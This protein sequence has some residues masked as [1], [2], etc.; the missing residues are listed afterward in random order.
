M[1]G[2]PL[3]HVV[4]DFD[5]T[6]G[7]AHMDLTQVLA[8]GGGEVAG[9]LSLR[10]TMTTSFMGGPYSPFDYNGELV[11]I[12]SRLEAITRDLLF[13]FN[14][15]Y[16]GADED[17]TPAPPIG[18][19]D[20]SSVDLNGNTAPSD[21][22]PNSPFQLFNAT[23]VQDSF[24]NNI[25]DQFDGVNDPT[26]FARTITFNITDPN[27]IQASADLDPTNAGSIV[28]A[29][30]DAT[31]INALIGLRS[32]AFDFGVYGT[33]YSRVTTL[34][35][36]YE[37]TVAFTGGITQ[38]NRDN[39]FIFRDREQQTEELQAS[40]SGV[41]LDEEFAKLINFQRGFESA[42]RMIRVGDELLSEIIN[43]FG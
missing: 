23:G 36:V 26:I 31:I 21:T 28:G 5:T 7:T 33:N 32:Q 18:D 29:P 4:F 37:E 34:E 19:H 24:D 20:P 17:P 38:R 30:G 15:V 16:L 22:T 11:E 10:G 40:Q 41:S 35:G 27:L 6:A 42:A 43:L 9:L 3:G 14:A 2:A 12:G 25:A 8:A 1:D 39:L 13:R